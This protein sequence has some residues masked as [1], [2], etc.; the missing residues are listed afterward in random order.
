MGQADIPVKRTDDRGLDEIRRPAPAR[1]AAI[2]FI[3][4]I[5]VIVATALAVAITH[6]SCRSPSH[7]LPLQ[8]YE[9]LQV[10]A[11]DFPGPMASWTS[12]YDFSYSPV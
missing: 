9:L 6:R 10:L 2:L 3:V 11:S 7:V 5:V 1:G 4:A 8:D 12:I